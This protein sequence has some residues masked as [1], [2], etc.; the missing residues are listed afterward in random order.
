M[1]VLKKKNGDVIAENENKTLAELA[2]ENKW[3]LR[4]ADLRSADLRRADLR[5]AEI[6]FHQ[7]PSIRLLSSMALLKI[8]DKII[9]ELMR[10]DADAHP[11]P[12]LFDEWAKGGACP[13]QNEERWWFMPEKKEVWKPGK[14]TMKLSDL[15]LEICR[16][17]GWGI[18][19][20]L[21]RERKTMGF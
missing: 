10:L 21:E 16:Q 3:N 8:S 18:K 1:A 5:S 12:E 6:E 19:G 13:Y 9:L 20:Y 11:K 15:I 7:F 17:E 4:T 2:N 14:P